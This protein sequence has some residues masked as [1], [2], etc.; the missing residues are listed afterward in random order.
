MTATEDA[1]I[2]LMTTLGEAG[3]ITGMVAIVLGL[4]IR[5]I[6]KN[7]CTCKLNSFSGQP[8]LVVDCEEGAPNK[9][10]LPKEATPQSTPTPSE[11]LEVE[12]SK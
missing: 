5:M 3:G 7:G 2:A 8:L 1:A 10:Y 11:Q 12:V 6:K 4:L 9:R